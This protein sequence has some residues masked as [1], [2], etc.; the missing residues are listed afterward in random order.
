[1]KRTLRAWNLV[2]FLAID[3]SGSEPHLYGKPLADYEPDE[4][5]RNKPVQRDGPE[6]T[7]DRKMPVHR[8]YGIGVVD[9]PA[10]QWLRQGEVKPDL[11]Y[12]EAGVR[13]MED[14]RA[15]YRHGPDG[16][17]EP[18][19]AAPEHG[20][21]TS[22]NRQ[23]SPPALGQRYGKNICTA[24]EMAEINAVTAA[25]IAK[26]YED[27]RHSKRAEVVRGAEWPRWPTN[28]GQL[29]QSQQRASYAGPQYDAPYQISLTVGHLDKQQKP[30]DQRQEAK[31]AAADDGQG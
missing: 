12:L 15:G 20:H 10:R 22:A 2:D 30:A 18:S 9:P 24:A 8:P 25:K 31:V 3:F 16:A 21:E 19:G 28:P 17:G 27:E 23:D 29:Y 4:A 6:M 1:M 11:P 7:E 14:Y 13:A 5:G 26:R